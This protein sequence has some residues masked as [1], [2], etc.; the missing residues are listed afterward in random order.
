MYQAIAIDPV[1]CS[2]SSP[3]SAGFLMTTGLR[4]CKFPLMAGYV[5]EH[6]R[7]QRGEYDYILVNL[8][9]HVSLLFLSG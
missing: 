7:R 2:R 6:L 1:H 9:A 3:L 4:I 5:C 8:S